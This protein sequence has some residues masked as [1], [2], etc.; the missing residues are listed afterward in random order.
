MPRRLIFKFV[1]FFA[2]ILLIS[3]I[4]TRYNGSGYFIGKI[5]VNKIGTP[6]F[7][8]ISP[9][10]G[11]VTY[12]DRE[13]GTIFISASEYSTFSGVRNIQSGREPFPKKMP[14]KS[15][16]IQAAINLVECEKSK[17]CVMAHLCDH[18]F[19]VRMKSDPSE[20]YNDMQ[21]RGFP[22]VELTYVEQDALTYNVRISY[23][24]D[25]SFMKKD[26]ISII[27][28]DNFLGE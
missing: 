21:K 8:N 16:G 22:V 6:V 27:G 4:S 25:C 10:Y 19:I 12:V 7:E 24:T 5:D 15:Y 2:I 17:S 18:N 13:K 9:K 28:K 23:F 20:I 26:L 11:S 1:P 3:C 14:L